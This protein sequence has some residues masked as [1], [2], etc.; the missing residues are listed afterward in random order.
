MDWRFIVNAKR[1][2]WR[3]PNWRSG[4]AA[5]AFGSIPGSTALASKSGVKSGEL[6]PILHPDLRTGVPLSPRGGEVISCRE[7]VE[8]NWGP[9]QQPDSSGLCNTPDPGF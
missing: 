7:L 5:P 4:D 1:C 6:A 2:E 3:S 9:H 8:E